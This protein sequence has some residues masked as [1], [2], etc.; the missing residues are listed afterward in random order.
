MRI[1]QMLVM[2]VLGIAGAVMAAPQAGVVEVFKS[3]TCGCCENYIS[4]LRKNGFTVAVTNVP[5]ASGVKGKYGVP[6]RSQSCHTALVNGYVV[7]G[8]VPVAAIQKLIAQRP[9]IK[10]I[11]VPGMVRNS[12]GMGEMKPGT[13]TV[14]EIDKTGGKPKVFSVE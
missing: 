13:L 6:E 9:N 2:A 14:Y 8:H 10:G 11:A 12:P 3:P 7:E 5:N 4:Y 1:N